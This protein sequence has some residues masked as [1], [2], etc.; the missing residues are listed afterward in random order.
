MDSKPDAA[1][2]KQPKLPS[3]DDDDDD[4]SHSDGG[5]TRIHRLD[6]PSFLKSVR[7][8]NESRKKGGPRSKKRRKEKGRW[9][10]N[11]QRDSYDDRNWAYQD[12]AEEFVPD[13]AS[14]SGSGSSS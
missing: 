13:P 6:E 11:I 10:C 8:Y 2:R 3:D 7:C 4:H 14:G 12:V 1:F 5:Q 9:V